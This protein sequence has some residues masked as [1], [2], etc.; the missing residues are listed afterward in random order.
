MLLTATGWSS[1]KQ[2][3]SCLEKKNYDLT[4]EVF[5]ILNLAGYICFILFRR[6]ELRVCFIVLNYPPG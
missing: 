1:A 4:A 6:K 5:E 2:S 3:C